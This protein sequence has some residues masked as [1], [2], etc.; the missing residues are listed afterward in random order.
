MEI[1][2]T[3]SLARVHGGSG[4]EHYHFPDARIP[5]NAYVWP[6][7]VRA[8]DTFFSARGLPRRVMDLGCGNGAFAAELARLGYDVVG[9]D[10]SITGIAQGRRAHPN[11]TLHEGSAYD[12]LADRYG[13]FSAVVS[14]EVVEHL[15]APRVFAQTAFSLLSNG[16]IALVS[17]PYHGYLKNLALAMSGKLDAHFTAL[18]DHG[19]IKFWSPRTLRALLIEAQFASVDFL[20]VGRVPV[21]AKS[22]IALASK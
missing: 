5:H 10:P 13:S 18:W 2:V 17:T 7:I 14:L 12:R 9:V 11:L 15:Y 6:P 4:P 8:L 3:D 1:C 16:G 20:R 21:F 19:H 22:M